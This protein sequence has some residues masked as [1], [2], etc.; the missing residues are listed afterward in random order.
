MQLQE[1]AVIP[2]CSFKNG[3]PGTSSHT[4]KTKHSL[5]GRLGVWILCLFDFL[6]DFV[7]LMPFGGFDLFWSNVNWSLIW[8]IDWL[9]GWLIGWLTDWLMDWFAWLDLI[10][11]DVELSCWSWFSRPD[12]HHNFVKFDMRVSKIEVWNKVCHRPLCWNHKFR[13]L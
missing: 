5:I 13:N 3:L 11:V 1:T 12:S 10:R 6:I 4:D 2:I 7:D 8:L 9:I